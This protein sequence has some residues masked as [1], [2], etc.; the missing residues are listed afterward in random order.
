[1]E[2]TPR[3]VG[4]GILKPGS[5]LWRG[6]TSIVDFIEHYGTGGGVMR[7]MFSEF[8][9]GAANVLSEPKRKASSARYTALEEEWTRLDDAALSH[10]VPEF[11]RARE[12]LARKEELL[13]TQGTGAT[14]KI[15]EA[16]TELNALTARAASDFPLTD[17]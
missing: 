14:A 5:N 15:A 3:T 4:R 11:H 2:P 1:M 8:L 6:L 17:D 9:S 10:D 12:L 7:P 13:L 16:W